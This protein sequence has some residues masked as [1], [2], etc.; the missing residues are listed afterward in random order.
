MTLRRCELPYQRN[1]ELTKSALFINPYS[2]SI[3]T[4]PPFGPIEVHTVGVFFP[5]F[6]PMR[7]SEEP[8]LPLSA[9]SSF[10]LSAFEFS[11]SCRTASEETFRSHAVTPLQLLPKYG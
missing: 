8:Y 4:L 7:V 3:A 6:Q 2:E 11:R 9:K 1:A 5:D 10:Y